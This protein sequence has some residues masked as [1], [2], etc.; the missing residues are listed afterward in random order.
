MAKK[1]KTEVA[2]VEEPTK[3]LAPAAQ[4][5]RALAK[6]TGARIAGKG[7]EHLTRED[8]LLPRLKLLQSVSPEVMEQDL[9]AGSIYLNLHNK[10]LGEKVIFTPILHYRSRIKFTPLDDGGGIDCSA[11]DAKTPRDTKYATE[12]SVCLFKDW[13]EKAEKKRD[14]RPQCSMF[15]NFV[16]VLEGSTEPVILSMGSTKLK[17]ARKF[18]SMAAVK[19]GDFFDNKYQ[20]SVVKEKGDEATFFN[21][22]ITDISKK[23]D[24]KTRAIGNA[25][26]ESLSNATITTQQEN[27]S[28]EGKVAEA[29]GAG[30]Y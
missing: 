19:G 11:P 26:W 5:S 20:L 28:E 3:A 4:K 30:K 25:L 27:E 29:A 2:K 23:T 22:L 12:C 9:K 14:Q 17:V 24:E 15:E 10:V 1:T 8:I 13:N 16:I 21:Y 18:Y 7:F 6:P